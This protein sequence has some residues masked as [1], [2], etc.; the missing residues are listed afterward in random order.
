MSTNNGGSY[1]KYDGGS[2]TYQDIRDGDK[3]NN[4]KKWLLGFIV[5][6]ALGGAYVVTTRKVGRSSKDIILKSLASGS[7]TVSVSKGKLKLFDDHSKFL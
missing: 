3:P 1:Q 2:G 5:A 6:I 4:R 7:S